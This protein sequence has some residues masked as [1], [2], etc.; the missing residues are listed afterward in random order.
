MHHSMG[1]WGSWGQHNKQRS[2]LIDR[3]AVILTHL[4]KENG[5]R[6]MPSQLAYCCQ[7]VRPAP[8]PVLDISGCATTTTTTF[9]WLFSL[10]RLI[11]CDSIKKHRQRF[12]KKTLRRSLEVRIGCNICTGRGVPYNQ[13][14]SNRIKESRSRHGRSALGGGGKANKDRPWSEGGK[15][16][17][18]RDT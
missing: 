11:L 9:L 7:I 3:C 18:H 15:R 10:F 16:R 1:P 12:K 2:S 4:G 17:R 14:E 6:Y 5:F 8:V 13:I